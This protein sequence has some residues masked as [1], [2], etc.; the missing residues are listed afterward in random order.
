MAAITSIDAG[1][2]DAFTANEQTLSADDTITI[3]ASKKQLLLLRNPT[4]GTLTAT[5][6]G[7]GGTSVIVPGLGSVSVAAGKAIAVP[8]L[9]TRAVV[10][11][12]ISAYTKGVVHITGASGMKV[13]LFNL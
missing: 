10:L 13:S 3:N 12:T 2:A 9:E 4:G 8:T 5:I 6:D 1:Q 7:D 11:N